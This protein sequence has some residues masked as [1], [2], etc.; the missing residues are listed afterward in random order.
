MI[1]FVL[2][3][4]EFD[5]KITLRILNP[6]NQ[7]SI[8]MKIRNILLLSKSFLVSISFSVAIENHPCHQNKEKTYK[9]FVYSCKYLL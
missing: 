5:S 9:L 2:I 6:E 8:L 3:D 1:F 7:S 4:N